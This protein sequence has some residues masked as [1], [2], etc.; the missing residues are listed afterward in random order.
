MVLTLTT[1]LKGIVKD[2]RRDGRG[3]QV[4]LKAMEAVVGVIIPGPITC[5]I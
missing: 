5:H 3:I 2:R 1:Q 4:I